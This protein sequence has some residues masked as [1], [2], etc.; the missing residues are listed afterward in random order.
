MIWLIVVCSIPLLV[1]VVERFY[2]NYRR[3]KENYAFLVERNNYLQQ[4]EKYKT[5][6]DA[7]IEA[8]RIL[9]EAHTKANNILSTAN[10]KALTA[11]SH[12]KKIILDAQLKAQE[13]A[14]DALDAR[15]NAKLYEQTARAMK[16]TILGYGSDYL[17][18]S[19]T[20]LDDLADTYGYSQA[21][22]DYKSIRSQIRNIIKNNQAATCDYTETSRRQTAINFITDAFNGK[23][24]TIL[25]KA[26]SDNFGTLRQKLTDAFSIVNYNGK[27]F[28]NARITNEYFQLRLE[29]L[30]LACLI[31]EIHRQDLEEQRRIRDQI[32]EEEKA[33]RD[34]DKALRDSAKEEELLQKAMKK[35]KAQLEKAHTEQRAV[36]EAK[37]AELEQK[38]LEAEERNKR[39]L[40]MA[41]QTKAGHVYIISNE[42]SFGPNIFKI[43][44]TRRLD[45]EDRVRELSSASV[46]FPFEIHAMIWSEDAPAL[47]N[48]LHKKFA[49][50]QVNKVNFRKEFFKLSLTEIRAELETTSLHIKWTITAEASEYRESLAIDK[51]IQA[52]S[53]AREDWLKHQ[54]DINSQRILPIYDEDQQEESNDTEN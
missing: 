2:A 15:D 31:A 39:A 27:A 16:N 51:A 10:A 1:F 30:R 34:F 33:R 4:F 43:G 11:N 21:S 37:I 44:M 13:I 17:I 7:C 40:S 32:R 8:T 20:L 46:P 23:A 6:D 42:G 50:A 9:N 12:A 35:A 14:G 48:M 24:D 29:E 47:E 49:L 22:Q 3:I 25:T 41:Q 38:Y 5:V 45:P 26:K 53:Q 28:K 19:R 18:P 54:L 36:Y 52:D